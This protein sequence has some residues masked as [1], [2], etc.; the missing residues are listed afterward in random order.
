MSQPLAGKQDRIIVELLEIFAGHF[1]ER[2]ALIRK[3]GEAEIISS[4][5]VGQVS[6]TVGGADLE[7]WKLIQ[8]SLLNQMRQRN[9]SRQGAADDISQAA[10]AAQSLRPFTET[11]RVD[12]YERMKF[13]SLCPKRVKLGIGQFVI[14]Y[15][16]SDAT[17]PQS[18]LLNGFFQLLRSFVGMFHSHAGQPDEAIRMAGA[19]LGHLFVLEAD[20]LP[21][22]IAVGPVPN[23]KLSDAE[24]LNVNSDIVLV[25]QSCIPAVSFQLRVRTSQH[26][27]QLP[28]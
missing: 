27:S 12:A 14:L 28:C 23:T 9:S 26:P 10:V 24:G 13:L 16:G 7:T 1:L 6:A 17:A 22:Q 19:K 21:G 2:L 8:R 3:D 20:D 11:L 18:Q 4:G 25:G 5:V 15:F